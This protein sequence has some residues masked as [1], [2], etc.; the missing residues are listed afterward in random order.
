MKAQRMRRLVHGGAWRLAINGC[1]LMSLI[2]C[3]KQSCTHFIAS[4]NSLHIIICLLTAS[5]V[6]LTSVWMM[7]R[8]GVG[9]HSSDNW[10]NVFQFCCFYGSIVSQLFLFNI[11]GN[12]LMVVVEMHFIRDVFQ[13][14]LFWS[15]G[16]LVIFLLL[17]EYLWGWNM[18]KVNFYALPYFT[19]YCK[20]SVM[21]SMV[22]FQFSTNSKSGLTIFSNP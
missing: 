22:I 1:D 20:S 19:G 2:F 5:S 13:E 3:S 14:L 18:A 6:R 10:P 17:C 8:L 7:A 4:V 16:S 12:L 21:F 9:V 15:L 11:I